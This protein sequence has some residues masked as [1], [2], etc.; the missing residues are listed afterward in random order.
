M[1]QF[2]VI[3]AA[4]CLV[5]GTCAF[6]ADDTSDMAL[7]ESV[8][9][10]LATCA[11]LAKA[12]DLAAYNTASRK[13]ADSHV[14]QGVCDE[15]ILWGGYNAG[16]PLNPDNH[17]LTEFDPRVWRAEYLAGF[18]FTGKHTVE[19]KDGYT[20]LFMDCAYRNKLD[21]GDYPYP[22]WHSKKKWDSY[23]RTT[24]LMFLF[25]KGHLTA[26]YRSP[27]QDASRPL[28]EKTFDGNWHWS[29]KDQTQPAVSLYTRIFSKDN[30]H[31]KDL[32]T[33]YR[34]LESAAR[35]NNCMSCHSPDNA[36]HAK[37]LVLLTFP[38]QALNAR[39][40]IVNE[41]QSNLMPPKNKD[42]GL[43]GVAD[44]KEKQKLVELAKTFAEL[45]DKALAFERKRVSENAA[46]VAAQSG[47]KNTIK[48]GD[49]GSKE[50]NEIRK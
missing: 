47:E 39:L 23:Q 7:I 49:S 15:T 12:D 2:P 30:P 26:S 24:N 32:E 42:T 41:L 36:A 27:E 19:K 9:S 44:E 22:F 11:P 4:L 40:T 16:K 1:R 14:L 10:N 6:G 33:A 21:A 20:V 50:L 29:E 35:Q 48:P 8:A 18:M 17:M 13:L 46:D 5:V 38:N 25:E 45:G 28:V 3:L 37:K 31:A 43:S 34:N